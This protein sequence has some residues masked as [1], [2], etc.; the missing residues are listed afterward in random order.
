ME[1]VGAAYIPIEVCPLGVVWLGS[2]QPRHAYCRQNPGCAQ[3]R[4]RGRLR[5]TCRSSPRAAA[6]LDCQKS[7]IEQHLCTDQRLSSIF[8]VPR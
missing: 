7:T 2:T 5:I 4:A 1:C 6:L 3:L 8:C